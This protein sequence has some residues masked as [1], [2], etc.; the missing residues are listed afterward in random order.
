MDAP[1]LYIFI[2]TYPNKIRFWILAPGSC[3]NET[4]Y[5]ANQQHPPFIWVTVYLK[6]SVLTTWEVWG[7]AKDALSRTL[8]GALDNSCKI[9]P[10]NRLQPL[11]MTST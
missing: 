1:C 7:K 11:S 8:L 2:Q 3:A 6:R 4:H 10:E 5:H 9:E